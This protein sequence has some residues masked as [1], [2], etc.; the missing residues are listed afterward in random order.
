MRRLKRGLFIFLSVAAISGAASGSLA[1]IE[2]R[3]EYYGVCSTLT[4]F[5]GLLQRAGL[6]QGGTCKSSP[7][8][9]LCNAGAAC[10]VNSVTGKCKNSA[11]PGGTAVCVCY[12]PPTPGT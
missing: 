4:G 11:L 12:T 8:G 5:P 2:T 9:N 6:L 10:T 3:I 1:V 7:G